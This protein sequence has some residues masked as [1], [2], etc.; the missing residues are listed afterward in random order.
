MS[1]DIDELRNKFHALVGDETDTVFQA[2]VTAV[3]E[4]EFTCTVRRD[5]AVDYFDVR[6]RGLANSHLQGFAFIPKAES[7]VLVCRIGKSNEL[8]VCQFT[9][10]EKIMF[11]DNDLE[12]EI[13][14]D[15]VD[16][17]KGEK[18]SI[19]LDAQKIE[20]TN[21]KTKITQ[22][23]GALSLVCD[24]ATVK[25]AT[26]GLTLKKGGSGLKKTLNDMLTA[27][28][29]LTVPTGVGPSGPPVNVAQFKSIQQ[30]LPNYMEE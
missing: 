15:K 28:A 24:Q 2:V 19:H 26:S 25:I 10:I 18:I 13:D 1:K 12:V 30:E 23:A 20:V 22:E 21:D 5:E 16:I 27:I 14:L 7:T 4:D 17:K 3:D 11:T 29:Q 8:F 9:E 6:L